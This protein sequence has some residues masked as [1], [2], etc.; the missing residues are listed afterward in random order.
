MAVRRLREEAESDPDPPVTR[1]LRTAPSLAS[2]IRE[3]VMAKSIQNVCFALEPLL[4]RVVHEEVERGLV[5]LVHPPLRSPQIC[6]EEVEPSSCL[7]LA[8]AQPLA[9]PIFTGSRI[10]DTESNAL[11]IL[12]TDTRT[13]ERSP[14]MLKIEIV[15]LDGDFPSRDQEHWTSNEFDSGIV[16]EREGKRPLLIGERTVTLRDGMAPIGELVF[17]DNSSW[18]RSRKFRLGA[19]VFPGSYEG[20][21]IKEALTESF[22]VKD[23]RGESYK[24]HYPPSL[25]DEVWRLEK[26]GKN[27]AF[28]RRLA[29]AGIRTVQEFLKQLV[30]NPSRLRTI[31]GP[32]MSERQWERSVKHAKTCTI[33][34]ERYLYC[35]QPYAVI[36]NPICEVVGIMIDDDIMTLQQLSQHQMEDFKQL[37]LEAYE[38]CNQ[39]QKADGISF[40]ATVSLQP[41]LIG[42][43]TWYSNHQESLSSEYQNGGIFEL[44]STNWIQ[45]AMLDTPDQLHEGY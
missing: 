19:R 40:S 42:S 30:I 7:Q 5:H 17:T 9:R 4:R 6:I 14:R 41:S 28:D 8:F 21:R 29:D 36:M 32:G 25:G 35:R 20:P 3:A 2:V 37:I 15:V 27:G 10:E 45:T 34:E 11:Q 16:K 43:S 13:G 23:H 26:I 33:G 38:H 18:I 12:L 31:L 39:L 22:T 24:K 44:E 1:R